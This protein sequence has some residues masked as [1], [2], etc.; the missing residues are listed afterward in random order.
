MQDLEKENAAN[1]LTISDL[2]A[3][4]DIIK[5]AATPARKLTKSLCC[6]AM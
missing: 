5:V 1:A 6:V 3:Q 4:L 2:K